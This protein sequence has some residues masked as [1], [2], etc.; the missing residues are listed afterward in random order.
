MSDYVVCGIYPVDTPW[1]H[2][3]Y[4]E[5]IFA[6]GDFKLPPPYPDLDGR[7]FPWAPKVSYKEL[8]SGRS[9]PQFFTGSYGTS[10]LWA[11]IEWVPKETRHHGTQDYD[12]GDS[13]TG[14]FRNLGTAPSEGT[15]TF[16]N[17]N[18]LKG[19][20]RDWQRGTR[21]LILEQPNSISSG[22]FYNKTHGVSYT[23]QWTTSPTGET[24]LSG[25]ILVEDIHSL[26]FI[27]YYRDGHPY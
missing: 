5:K 22:T 24:T 6:R 15:Y 8:R 26:P 4:A 13:F 2:S 1:S 16:A 14:F 18:T 19:I 12:N 9:Y 7:D 3:S 10:V 17:G 25:Y 11:G 21:A 23:G 20:F 27:V